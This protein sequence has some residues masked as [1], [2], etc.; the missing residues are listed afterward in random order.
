MSSVEDLTHDD[1]PRAA[2]GAAATAGAGAGA[3]GPSPFALTRDRKKW[4]AH[5]R[6]ERIPLL[7]LGAEL[8]LLGSACSPAE[9]G[10]KNCKSCVHCLHGLG[11]HKRGVWDAKGAAA[12]ALLGADPNLRARP[13]DSH[14]GLRNLGATWSV[15]GQAHEYS[16]SRTRRIQ[17]VAH[18]RSFLSAL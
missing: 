15:D 16:R 14:V 4:F 7:S 6:D 13:A 18:P 5:H 12:A 1:S 8:R 2:T 10:T 17:H 3:G 9:A 11:L